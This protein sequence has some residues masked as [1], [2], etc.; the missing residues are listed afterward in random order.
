MKFK[1][2]NTLLLILPL[3]LDTTILWN[4]PCWQR[5]SKIGKDAIHS[6]LYHFHDLFFKKFHCFYFYSLPFFS[7]S[8]ILVGKSHILSTLSSAQVTNFKSVGA[9]LYTLQY[10]I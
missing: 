3:I 4:D 9:T 2:K 1:N 10:F 8:S 5:Q 6:L 7:L